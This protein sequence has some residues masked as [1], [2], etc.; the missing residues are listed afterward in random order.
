[1]KRIFSFS[2]LVLAMASCK[3]DNDLTVSNELTNTDDV[4][5]AS[6]SS[7]ATAKAV[8]VSTEAALKDA[9]KN[10]KPGDVITISNTINLTSTLKLDVSG[11]SSAKITLQGGILDGSKLPTGA[12][13]VGL[14]GNFWIIKNM[15]IRKAKD[16]GI[17]VQNGGFNLMTGVTTT[18][19]E[20]TG[21]QIYN[22]AHDNLVSFCTSTENFD[23]A[24]SGENADGFACK[25]SSGKNNK[26][27]HCTANHNSDDGWDLFGNPYSVIITNCTASNNGFGGN[28]DGNGFKLGSAGQNIPHTVTN[29]RS[30][31][32]KKS[33]YD[34]NGNVG[35]MTMTG[36]TGSGN[37]GA[38][39]S[40]I[41]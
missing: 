38:L 40:R 35:H 14:N 4:A 2:L 18:G 27:D 36:S 29:N 7:S 6:S 26:F 23:K 15:T 39:F 11:T 41:F 9:V 25:L 19:C 33:G 16:N 3:K 10:A 32:N 13:G 5:T 12:R 17:V 28:G 22:G 8:T 1:M 31:N 34:G 20:D 37:G 24:N 30:N 21:I